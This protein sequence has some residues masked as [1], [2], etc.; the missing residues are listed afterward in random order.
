MMLKLLISITPC[1]SDTEILEELPSSSVLE[2]SERQAAKR[3]SVFTSKWGAGSVC[4]LHEGPKQNVRDRQQGLPF[5]AL[6]F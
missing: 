3:F 2:I 6:C 1:P 4:L 5:P